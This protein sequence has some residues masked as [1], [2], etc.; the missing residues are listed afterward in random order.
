MHYSYP[1][2]GF[3]LVHSYSDFHDFSVCLFVGGD[4]EVV[5]AFV[6]SFRVRGPPDQAFEPLLV[7]EAS[8]SRYG[9]LIDSWVHT[10][11]FWRLFCW[12]VL[13]LLSSDL[14]YSKSLLVAAAHMGISE[15]KIKL[16]VER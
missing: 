4:F 15:V 13:H 5:W 12:M 14:E 9:A 6:F 2:V 3:S 8:V 1:E 7:D 16:T 11:W 10:D